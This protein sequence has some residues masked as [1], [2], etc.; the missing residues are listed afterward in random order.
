MHIELLNTFFFSP[1]DI[2]LILAVM[3]V[4]ELQYLATVIYIPELS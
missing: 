3:Y 1:G 4:N 2:P